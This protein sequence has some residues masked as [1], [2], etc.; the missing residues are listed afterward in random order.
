MS[1]LYRAAVGAFVLNEDKQ[2]LITRNFGQGDRWNFPR[3]GV[4]EGET[5]ERALIRELYE[6]LGVRNAKII[7][8]SKITTIFR[9]PADYI[10]INNL[11][12]MGQAQTWYWVF[13]RKSVPLSVPNNEAEEYRWIDLTASE[14]SKFFKQHDDEKVMQTFLPIEFEEI[15]KRLSEF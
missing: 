3:G 12:Y 7:T 11:N 2:I 9:V 15:K 13:L 1:Q 14:I 6:E 5:D 4:E 10:K 8:K